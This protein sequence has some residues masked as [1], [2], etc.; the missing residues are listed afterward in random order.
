MSPEAVTIVRTDPGHRDVRWC[1]ERYFAE[2]DRRFETGFDVADGAGEPPEIYAP[3]S[4]VVLV[5]RRGDDPVG[6]GALTIRADGFAEIKRMWVSDPVR[7]TGLGQRLLESLENFASEAGQ[8]VVR[9]DSNRVLAEAHAL[10]RRN[11]Y[12]EI[13]RYND[14]PY[15]HIWFEKHI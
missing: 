7:G 9:L 4:G 15:A 11:G 12:A 13:P 14:N 8:S 3:P 6:C 2:I 1:V 5:A 10:Y